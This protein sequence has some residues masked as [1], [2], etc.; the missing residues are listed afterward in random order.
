MVTGAY[1]IL[2]R[3]FNIIMNSKLSSIAIFLGPIFLMIVVGVVLQNSELRNINVGIYTA[4]WP[5]MR[6]DAFVQGFEQKIGQYVEDTSL[7]KCKNAV[8]NGIYNACIEIEKG[9]YNPLGNQGIN[10]SSSVPSY[11]VISYVDFS[12]TQIVWGVI[13]RIQR[14][15]DLQVQSMASTGISAAVSKIDV[16]ISQIQAQKDNLNAIEQQISSLESGLQD[17]QSNVDSMQFQLS[18]TRTNI[19]IIHSQLDSLKT[20]A[21]ITPEMVNYIETIKSNLANIDSSAQSLGNQYNSN[22][23]SR[24]SSLKTQ[25]EGMRNQLISMSVEMSNILIEWNALKTTQ[26]SEVSKPITSDYKSVLD[27]SEISSKQSLQSIDYLFPSFLMFFIIF[28]SLVFPATFIIRERTSKAYIR[29]ATSKVRGRTFAIFNFLSCIILISVQ[30]LVI[31]VLSRFFLNVNILNNI[32]PTIIII[33]VAISTLSL[34]GMVVG[35][36]FDNHEN[37][38]VTAISVSLM[39]LIFLPGITPSETLPSPFSSLLKYLPSTI[40]EDKLRMSTLFGTGLSFSFLEIASILITAIVS[41][42]FITIL[43]NKNK[44]KEI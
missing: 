22:I 9:E 16:M 20:F 17:I 19:Q 5:E 32:Y 39:F 7:D 10:T 36:L 26:L 29:N 37:A 43:Y 41:I 27:S 34:L 18:M 1:A 6:S 2:K 42:L 30:I 23:T 4:N 11:Q 3:N 24:A 35:Y 21:G 12:K 44:R 15:T 38:I 14:V 13:N 8:V 40:F 25:V 31:I 33:L 28:V